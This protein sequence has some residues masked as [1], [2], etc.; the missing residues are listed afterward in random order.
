MRC[1]DN[2]DLENFLLSWTR[3]NDAKHNQNQRF[4]SQ[5]NYSNMSDFILGL[6]EIRQYLLFCV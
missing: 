6:N 1:N 2:N 5:E 4:C 3:W